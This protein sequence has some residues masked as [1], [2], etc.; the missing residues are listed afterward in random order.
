MSLLKDMWDILK[1][2][3]DSRRWVKRN[4]KRVYDVLTRRAPSVKEVL[5]QQRLFIEQLVDNQ[6]F[7]EAFS[8]RR[9]YL[10][11]VLCLI[12]RSVVAKERGV[13]ISD[14]YLNNII[15][16]FPRPAEVV[17]LKKLD[18]SSGFLYPPIMGIKREYSFYKVT[19]DYELTKILPT[20]RKDLDAVSVS[21]RA[22][23]EEDIF[24]ESLKQYDLSLSRS[25]SE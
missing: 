23:S 9:A 1:S 13:L 5:G 16:Y 24:R 21:A 25:L 10:E 17:N 4:A 22:K 2:D 14:L 3:P 8:S 15:I 19:G 20:L 12:V 18:D 6:G 11:F 7:P